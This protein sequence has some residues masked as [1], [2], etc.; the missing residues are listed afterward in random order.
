ML[1]ITGRVYLRDVAYS[2]IKDL[3]IRDKLN[4][5]VVSEND[6]ASQLNMSRTPI[7]EALKKLQ[8]E[9]FLEIY[10][11][12]GIYIKEMLVEEAQDLMD[13]RLAIELFS[14]DT[15]HD[16]FRASDLDILQRKI[17]EQEIAVEE[18]DIYEFIKLDLSYHEYLLKISGNQYFVKT[19]NNVNDLI[20]RHGMRI[21]KRN[22]SHMKKSIEDHKLINQY[23]GNGNFLEARTVMEE[24]IKRG[25]RQYLLK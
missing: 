6:L 7:R 14:I 25:K 24:H 22:M 21:F 5:Q 3:I 11:Q 2:K 23:L 4:S 16:S 18:G 8:N 13:V 9:D 12:K 1:K 19:L 17:K 15:I 20:F 10:P